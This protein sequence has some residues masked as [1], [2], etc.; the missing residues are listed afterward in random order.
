MKNVTVKRLCLMGVLVAIAM[1]FSYVESL[2]PVF[3][4][5]PGI[6]LGLANI[7]VLIALLMLGPGEAFFIGFVRIMLSALLF[8]N[9][10]SLALSF[11]GF[12]LSFI[13]MLIVKK[14]DRFTIP[15]ISMTGGFFHNLAQLCCASLILSSGGIMIYTFPLCIVG[16]ITG[17]I[18]GFI[19]KM[20]Y[21]RGDMNRYDR[22]S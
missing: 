18:N 9:L 16:L 17:I 10:F 2:I 1:L 6:R 14:A 3:L 21:E 13:S 15:G 12:L 20:I 7:I 22:M 4:P 8:G 5:I 19:A 11:S